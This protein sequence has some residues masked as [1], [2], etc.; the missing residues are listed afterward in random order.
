MD[1]LSDSIWTVVRNVIAVSGS[2]IGLFAGFNRVS[3]TAKARQDIEWING[4]ID[5]DTDNEPR[6]KILKELRLSQEGRLIAAHYVPWW[7]FMLLPAW[8]IW[9]CRSNDTICESRW[10]LKWNCIVVLNLFTCLLLP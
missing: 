2:A 7:K 1:L 6:Q 3:R 4:T 10:Q 5:K 9:L 8:A